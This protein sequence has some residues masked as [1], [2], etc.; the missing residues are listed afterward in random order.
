[1]PHS[2]PDHEDSI[3]EFL[4]WERQVSTRRNG[5]IGP[6]NDE[7]QDYVP[8]SALNAHFKDESV[9]RRVISDLGLQDPPSAYYVRDLY[10]QVF[11]ILLSIHKGSMIRQFTNREYLNDQYLPFRAKPSDFPASSDDL[12]WTA[13]QERQWRFRPVKMR[14]GMSGEQPPAAILP[15]TVDDQIGDGVSASIHKIMV[16]SEYN[17]LIKQP[18]SA[19]RSQNE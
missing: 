13:F 3:Q 16:D 17:S 1:M 14:N 6:Q 18:V 9:V 10:L 8:L 12:L 5:T 15:F 19:T 4:E 7:T 11:A 2:Q